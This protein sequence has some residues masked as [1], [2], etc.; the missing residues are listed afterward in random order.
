MELVVLLCLATAIGA[1]YLI[2]KSTEDS[3]KLLD[4]EKEQAPVPEVAPAPA[5]K[6]RATKKTSTAVK[7]ATAAKTP[8]AKPATR[9]KKQ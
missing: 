3:A 6:T 1:G 2:F 9:K 4:K 8:A 5:K 7:F